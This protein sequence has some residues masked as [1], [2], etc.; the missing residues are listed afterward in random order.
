MPFDPHAS[1]KEKF[2]ELGSGKTYAHTRKK[3]GKR[4]ADKQRVAIVLNSERRN[5]KRR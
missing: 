4:A 2:R 3:K 1:R 5:R